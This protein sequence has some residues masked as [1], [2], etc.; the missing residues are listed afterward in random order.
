M[1]DRWGRKHFG[2][3]S[4]CTVQQLLD[5]MQA[6]TTQTPPIDECLSNPR[7]ASR[8]KHLGMMIRAVQNT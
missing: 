1:D 3:Q 8:G 2:S 4:S 7:F 6:P 5:S